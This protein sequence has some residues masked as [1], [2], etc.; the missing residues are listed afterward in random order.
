M[1]APQQRNVISKLRVLL[2]TKPLLD[3]RSLDLDPNQGLLEA[4]RVMR[5]EDSDKSTE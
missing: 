1:N 4:V 5:P 2:H 3:L